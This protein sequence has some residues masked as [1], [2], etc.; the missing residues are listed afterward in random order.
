[1]ILGKLDQFRTKMANAYQTLADEEDTLNDQ[2]ELLN[3]KIEGF[4]RGEEVNVQKQ[5]IKSGNK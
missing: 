5:N 3:K 1:M 4:G 2:L